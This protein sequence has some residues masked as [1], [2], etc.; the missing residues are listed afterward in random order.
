VTDKL[1]GA[2]PVDPG[3]VTDF[4]FKFTGACSPTPAD[5]TIGSSC[6]ADTTADAIIPGA[7]AEG[8][9]TI[10]EIGTVQVFDGGSDGDVDTL[11]NTL[12]ERQGI[13]VP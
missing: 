6:S 12:F 8:K 4:P 13:F 7:V 11:P 5:T 9:R 3:T 10:W 1:N 2:A